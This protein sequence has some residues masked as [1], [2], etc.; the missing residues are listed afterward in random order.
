MQ[1]SGEHIYNGL[2]LLDVSAA[3]SSSRFLCPPREPFAFLP[4]VERRLYTSQTAF[5]D[6]TAEQAWIIML[7]VVNTKLSVVSGPLETKARA[8]L[9]PLFSLL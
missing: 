8:C 5:F 9:S 6:E 7:F 1:Y 3:R 4:A 2:T